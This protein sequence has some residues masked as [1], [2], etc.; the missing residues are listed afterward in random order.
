M[1]PF[2]HLHVHTE[3]S[4]L[5]GACTI[6]KLV[7]K[8]KE[9]G[10]P[11]I[12]ITDHGNMM[13]AL[14]FY[15]EC[16]KL[17]IKP[18]IGCEFYIAENRHVKSGKPELFHLILLAKNNTGYKNLLKLNS[19]AHVEGFYYKPRID[20]EVLK[21][22]SEGLICLSAC[23]AG[24]VPQLLLERRFD[25]AEKLALK[26][27][28]LFDEGDYY[29][30]LQNHG[31]PEQIE[32]LE[33]L[34]NLA[35]KIGVKTVATNDAHY[36]NKSDAE[37]QDI[38]LCIQTGRFVDEPNRMKFETEEFYIKNMEEMQQ[39]LGAYPEALE[40]PYEIVEKCQV[41]IKA[42]SHAEID[43]SLGIPKDS[44]LKP[45]EAF[46]PVF[47]APDGMNNYE[48]MKKVVYD[49]LEKRYGKITKELEERAE[50]ELELIKSGGF[51]EY[52]LVVWDYVAYAKSQGIPVGPGRGSGAGSIV[53]Y[54]MGITNVE[55][56]QYNLLFERFIHKERVSMPDFDIDF[57]YDR[58][59]EIIE[60][61]KQKYGMDHVS[62][63]GTLGTMAAKNAIK[64]VGRVLRIPY[65]EVDK[66][67][68]SIPNKLPDGIKKPPVLK[69]YFGTTG[70][71]EDQKY[72]L[73]E[74]RAYYDNDE[75]LKKVIDLGIKLEGMP[76]QSSTHACGILI[77]PRPVSDFVPLLRNGEEIASQFSMVELEDLGLLK[78][79][80]LG[81][82]TLTDI[83][84]TV[85][86]IKKNFNK[87]IDFD[88]MGVDDP[89]VYKL[90]T[91]GDTTNIFQIESS[92][93][94]DLMRKLK[95]DCLED[96]I[97]AISM[98]RPGPMD[99]IPRFLE[100]KQN[101]KNIV[102]DHP[103]LEPI[104]K[105]TYGVIVYQEQ[106]MKI[107]QVMAGYTL[108]QADNVRRIMGKKKVDQM[109]AERK[110]FI[111]GWQD[112]KGQKSI[113]G[114][115]ALGVKPEVA[116]KVF[117]EME[118]FAKYAFNKSHSAGYA[119]LT[120]Q[121]AWLKCY[122]PVE[123]L[124]SVLNN[125]ITNADEIK[126]YLIY[127]KEVK[128]EVLPPDINKSETYF[129]VENGKIRFGLAALK[130]VGI[131]MTDS[132][133]EER[134][135][136]GSFA[137]LYDLISRF[138]GTVNK[139]YMESLIYSGALDSFG[140]AR[141]QLIEVF[142][143]VI[144]MAYSTKKTQATGQFS[145]F[146]NEAVQLNIVVYPDI[147]EYSLAAKLKF[148]KQVTGVYISGHPLDNYADKMKNFNFN[149]SKLVVSEDI[150]ANDEM[151][152]MEFIEQDI[153]NDMQ[154]NTG[155]IVTEIRKM[156]TKQGNR[157]MAMLKLEDLY[158]SMDLMMFPNIYDRY[159]DKLK[160]DVMISVSGRLSLRPGD[161]P[162]ILV[163]KMGFWAAETEEEPEKPKE[164]EKSSQTLYL[165][166]DTTDKLLH[167]KIMTILKNSIGSVPVLIKCGQTDKSFRIGLKVNVDNYLLNELNA[168]IKEEFIKVM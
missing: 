67:T 81:L 51:I 1:K 7:E 90:V 124:V 143:Q 157:E 106:V 35:K 144:D 65:A 117:H 149:S 116:E 76:R 17:G 64:D 94:Q 43:S 100:N 48:Y 102:Y 137:D 136:N 123:F 160:E 140:K 135:K 158:G 66:I 95:P 71:E 155:G 126:R 115:V 56:L 133:I 2:I 122:Y 34:Y 47:K 85:K 151:H 89:N 18:I 96:I 42:K 163:E 62:Y 55:P 87:D 33:P 46:I 68:K 44:V 131:G 27:K 86:L 118:N 79:D 109:D 9:Q 30:E 162:T 147:K 98:Y 165:K 8:V 69:Y 156:Y 5:D 13:G 77:T 41:S 159:K 6:K 28:S 14:K 139:R 53:A 161:T 91:S 37:M 141:S 93:F 54:A 113:P 11:A 40:T 83:D 50:T 75:R 148:E 128:I 105:E 57:C 63:I 120:Y 111:N 145:L 99:Y 153:V 146:E 132:I 49:G 74:L 45:S 150:N 36:I 52:F 60:Y 119:V 73:P 70:K 110:K 127:A 19:I 138:A 107:V 164:E 152:E 32:V 29:I 15:A 112:P 72:V 129:S 92:G 39:V 80:F 25:E 104:L 26:Y 101:P 10:A 58:R 61:V 88:S 3:Y 20:Y 22:H 108:G 23:L 154:V 84:R 103:C 134:T 24:H 166:Y 38:L 21:K 97:A 4:L 130:N 12:A 59:S 142:D 31:L 125:R 167:Q 16:F 78:M 121:T 82:R 168:L 114:A